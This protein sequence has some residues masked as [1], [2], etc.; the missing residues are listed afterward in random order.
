MMNSQYADNNWQTTLPLQLQSGDRVRFVSPSSTPEKEGVHRCSQIIESW[1]LQVELGKHVF[2][3]LGYLA[4]SDEERLGDINDALR[5]PGVRAIFATTGGK[6]AY[7]IADQL[8]FDA[9]SRNPKIIVGFSDITVLHLSLW[10]HC[11]LVGI[12]GPLVSWSPEYVGPQSIESLRKAVMTTEPVVLRSDPNEPTA[13]LTTAGTVTGRLIGGNLDTLSISAGW[14]LPNLSGAIL[15]IEAVAMGLGHVDRQ[16]TMLL[17]AGHLNGV[18]GIAVG[19][20]TDFHAHGAW[21]IID[22]LRDRLA[23]LNVPILGGLP[24]GHDKHPQTTPL[25]TVATLDAETG[26]LTVMPGVRANS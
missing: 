20:F 9:A 4:G 5:D 17:N 8:D 25:G 15:L 21:T 3:E 22:V 14:A 18:K 23:R 16:L 19:R 2:R 13:A 6:G 12:H 7:R 10:R 11:Q 1:G 26:T 24:I